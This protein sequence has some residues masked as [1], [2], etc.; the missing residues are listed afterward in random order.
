MRSSQEL[1]EPPAVVLDTNAALDWLLFQDPATSALSLA[2]RAG[3]LRWLSCP[4]MRDEFS[5][6]LA[7]PSLAGYSPDSVHML[8]LFDVWSQPVPAPTPLPAAPVCTDQDDQIFVD[9][10][11]AQQARWLVTRDRALLKLAR[12][13]R[14]L[15]L[16]IVQPGEWSLA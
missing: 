6:V 5:R 15:G 10:A 12:R 16:A 11:L 3:K 4:R 14:A 7:Y 2:I 9:L 1:P 13:A 8:T